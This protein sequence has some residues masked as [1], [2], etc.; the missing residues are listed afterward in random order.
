MAELLKLIQARLTSSGD[1]DTEET[2]LPQVSSS[3]NNEELPQLIQH[4]Q[5]TN[6]Q[7]WLDLNA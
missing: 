4:P 5:I 7:Q 6:L 2:P 1:G 3:S